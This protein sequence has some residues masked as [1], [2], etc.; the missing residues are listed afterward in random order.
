[1]RD[2]I[3]PVVVEREIRRKRCHS[4][5]QNNNRGDTVRCADGEGLHSCQLDHPTDTEPGCD[6]DGDKY[7]QVV[8]ILVLRDFVA[9]V[10]REIS[11]DDNQQKPESR[12]VL[13]VSSGETRESKR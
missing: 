4:G 5:K 8:R 10:V 7:R 12:A 2:E 13:P 6:R 1:M 11:E 3:M 9:E